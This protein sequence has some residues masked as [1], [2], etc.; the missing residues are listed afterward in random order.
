MANL[1]G[2]PREAETREAENEIIDQNCKSGSES[3][4]AAQYHAF[5]DLFAVSVSITLYFYSKAEP[6]RQKGVLIILKKKSREH[7]T[8]QHKKRPLGGPPNPPSSCSFSSYTITMVKKC[9][10]SM[11]DTP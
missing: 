10:Y 2:I 1:Y 3:V 6:R 7:V 8:R 9:T 4:W 5:G 11:D